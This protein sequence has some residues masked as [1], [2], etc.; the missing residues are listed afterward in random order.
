M[1]PLKHV[2]LRK[3]KLSVC[4]QKD[5]AAFFKALGNLIKGI[6]KAYAGGFDPDL[7]TDACEFIS[8]V[9]GSSSGELQ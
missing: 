6:S 5:R 2:F 3:I 1:V 7:L 4:I 8:M 9:A